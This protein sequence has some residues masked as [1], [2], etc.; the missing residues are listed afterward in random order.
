MYTAYEPALAILVVRVHLDIPFED[1]PD[2]YVLMGVDIGDGGISTVSVS[3]PLPADTQ[4]FGDAWLASQSSAL[5]VVPS[6][7][8]PRGLN[9][10][11]NPLHPDT[12]RIT[13]SEVTD[14]AFDGRLWN[15][16]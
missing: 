10:L 5:L 9:Y 16:S 7:L 4:A 15:K 11:I 12:K 6:V 3:Y 1:I 2:D 13:I 14:F 8:A